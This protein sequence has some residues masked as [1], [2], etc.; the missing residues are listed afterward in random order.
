MS[1]PKNPLAESKDRVRFL[2]RW[3]RLCAELEKFDALLN[4]YESAGLLEFPRPVAPPLPPTPY[5]LAQPV[6]PIR[7]AK[8][9]K[10]AK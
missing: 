7:P 10:T 6:K 4:E 3:N 5:P 1:R 9:K 8:P 2:R